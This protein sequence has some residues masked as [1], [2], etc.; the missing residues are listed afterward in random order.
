MVAMHTWSQVLA[1]MKSR[2][3]ALTAVSSVGPLLAV[4][5]HSANQATPRVPKMKNTDD[6][7]KL[8][9]RS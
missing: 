4:F 8:R 6:H 2:S 1:T 9:T 7:P 5:T 3:S